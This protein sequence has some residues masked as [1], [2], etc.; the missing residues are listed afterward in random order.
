MASN[1]LPLF[2]IVDKDQIVLDL[3]DYY[4]YNLTTEAVNYAKAAEA[5]GTDFNFVG[6]TVNEV[7]MASK[8]S[9]G[10]EK[11]NGYRS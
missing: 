4:L 11:K 2:T 10:E 8:A 1:T 6:P 5:F 3:V 9:A 7:E